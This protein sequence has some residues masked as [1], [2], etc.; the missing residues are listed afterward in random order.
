MH[1]VQQ[2]EII[3]EYFSG[4]TLDAIGF[5]VFPQAFDMQNIKS[6]QSAIFMEGC[7]LLSKVFESWPLH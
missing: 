3:T 1:L 7:R 6:V 5:R 4:V 2:K